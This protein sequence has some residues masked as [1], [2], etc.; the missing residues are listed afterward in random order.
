MLLLLRVETTPG[1]LDCLVLALRGNVWD[2]SDGGGGGMGGGNRGAGETGRGQ[3]GLTPSIP[4]GLT[5]CGRTEQ[6]SWMKGTMER[7]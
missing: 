5:D 4:G 6:C 3:G 1:T 7:G 2:R